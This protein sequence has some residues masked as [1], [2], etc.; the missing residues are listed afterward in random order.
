[1]TRSSSHHQLNL[2]RQLSLSRRPLGPSGVGVGSHRQR[3]AA[4]AY[5]DHLVSSDCDSVVDYANTATAA[6]SQRGIRAAM[7]YD[8]RAAA[9]FNRFL[10]GRNN[11]QLGLNANSSG[12][13][14]S[15]PSNCWQQ[16]QQQQQQANYATTDEDDEAANS[17]LGFGANQ[18]FNGQANGVAGVGNSMTRSRS[19][20]NLG[21]SHSGNSDNKSGKLAD[22]S[23]SGKYGQNA[24][25]T[26]SKKS[27]I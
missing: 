7:G 23:S 15:S 21:P 22:G 11:E 6:P 20:C 13:F 24:T 2:A 8:S 12:F 16:S 25:G 3:L 19:S 18:H 1:M 4:A 26:H 27:K 5:G 17:D 10:M 14:N 9:D